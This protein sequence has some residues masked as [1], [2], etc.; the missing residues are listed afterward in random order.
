MRKVMARLS[1]SMADCTGVRM[2]DMA[3]GDWQRKAASEIRPA[4]RSLG[5][6]TSLLLRLLVPVSK[7]PLLLAGALAA[8]FA[9]FAAALMMPR[10]PLP[11]A[12]ALHAPAPAAALPAPAWVGIIKPIEIFSLDAAD[13]SK[14][15]NTYQARRSPGG[16]RQDT[17]A[18]G[19]LASDEPAIR[20]TLYRRGEEAYAP[21]PMFSDTARIAA[22]AGLSVGKSGLP[23]LMTTRFGKFQVAAVTLSASAASASP[24]SGFRLILEAPALTMTGLAC[25]GK[26]AAMTRERLACLLER[27]DLTSG[28]ADKK[29]IEF[30]A[31]TELKRNAT[32]AGMRLGP[33]MVHAAWLD[34]RAATPRKIVRHR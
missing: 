5:S 27:L 18:Y 26:A 22:E 13:L 29:L 34:D 12:G 11:T 33:D 23:D 30:F 7:H 8:A 16:G 25:G 24:C 19:T 10:I 21:G 4:F 31:Q 32:C 17:L 15:T 2:S 9:A 20:L 3:F 1:V 14:V 28:G 6:A